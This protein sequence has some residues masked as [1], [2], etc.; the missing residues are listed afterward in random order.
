MKNIIFLVL[1]FWFTGNLY[2]QDEN[3]YLLLFDDFQQGVAMLKTNKKSTNLFNYELATGKVLFKNNDNIMELADP[4]SISFIKIGD[5]IFEHIKG[6]DFYEKINVGN[7]D[8]YIYHKGSLLSKGK[9]VGYGARSQTSSTEGI[10]MITNS[11]GRVMK[12]NVDEDFE[13]KRKNIYYLK[14]DGK[15]KRFNSLSSFAKLFKG[16]ES[17]IEES[18][19]NERLN[20][21]DT[22]D[23]IK[24]ISIA[25]NI[26]GK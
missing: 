17:Q 9:N 14:I 8:L 6:R 3:N 15:F 18:L 13:I 5:R 4:E 19:K 24:A 11:E 21:N 25:N 16:Q 20:F 12:L 23:I 22:E 2:S 26:S 7:T 10:N 1:F